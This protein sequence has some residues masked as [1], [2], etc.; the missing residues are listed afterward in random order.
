MED[1]YKWY[2]YRQLVFCSFAAAAATIVF[3]FFLV[4]SHRFA[5]S[6]QSQ[7]LF[8]SSKAR[9]LSVLMSGMLGKQFRH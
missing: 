6:I 9:K 1:G 5:N 2:L 4:F 3:F 7:H 8:Y